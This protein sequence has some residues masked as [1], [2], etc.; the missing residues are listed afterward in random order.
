MRLVGITLMIALVAASSVMATV[1]DSWILGIDHIV[2]AGFFQTFTGSG[3]SSTQSSGN[4]QYTGNAYGPPISCFPG[5]CKSGDARIY[6]SLSGLST[7]GS[8]LPTTTE[9]YSVKFYGTAQPA[10]NDWQPIEVDFNGSQPGDGEGLND[11]AIPWA[12]ESG[13]NH[14]Y[15]GADAKTAGQF[16][17]AGPGPHAPKSAAYNASGFDG[18]YVWLNSGSWLYAKWNF[19]GDTRRSWSAI[20]LTQ[21]TPAIGPPPVGDFNKNNFVDAADYALW[22]KTFDDENPA[23]GR[24]ADG[25]FDGYV[26]DIDYSIW[27]RHFGDKATGISGAGFDLIPEPATF[28]LAGFVA[29][30]SLMAPRRRPNLAANQCQKM[31]AQNRDQ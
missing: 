20:Q 10:N 27:R 19:P 31:R 23:A 6:W 17:A 11:P 24:P 12:G 21:V 14:Q 4:A 13:T 22:R 9:L 5:N 1:G 2:N 18:S 15:I 30:A 8:A 26:D 28:S 3:Y 7:N 25:N 16:R 29:I